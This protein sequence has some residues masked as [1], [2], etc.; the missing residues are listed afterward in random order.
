MFEAPKKQGILPSGAQKRWVEELREQLL[1]AVR[2]SPFPEPPA[3]ATPA[4]EILLQ[5]MRQ[6]WE[7]LQ[8]KK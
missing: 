5:A 8:R 2:N 4:R 6:F 7:L 1:N 3:P